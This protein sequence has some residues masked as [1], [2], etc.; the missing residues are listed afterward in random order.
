MANKK[1]RKIARQPNKLT[2]FVFR[3]IL[4][5]ALFAKGISFL[6]DKAL[7]ENLISNS[8]P[9]EKF[10]ILGLL[11]PY[12]HI[13]GGFFIIIG[14]YIRAAILIQIPI[15]IGAIILLLKS[16]GKSYQGEIIFAALILIMLIVQLAYGDGLYSWRNLLNKEKNIT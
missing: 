5:I 9:Q 15:I 10:S 6:R 3:I 13:A 12:V 1:N 11:I 8:I 7:L 2:L 14:L 4:G 16:G